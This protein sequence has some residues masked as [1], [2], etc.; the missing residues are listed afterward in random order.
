MFK[1][2]DFGVGCNLS[3][4]R[5]IIGYTKEFA[6]LEVLNDIDVYDPILSDVFS[7]GMTTIHMI[8]FNFTK[9]NDLDD[10]LENL[11]SDPIWENVYNVISKMRLKR[12]SR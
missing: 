3:K 11:R 12:S 1:I 2:A 7:L 5:E 9:I 4:N 10:F 6:A 8:D